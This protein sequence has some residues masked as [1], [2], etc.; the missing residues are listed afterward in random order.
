MLTIGDFD[1]ISVQTGT[2]RLDGGAMFGVVPK[3]IWGRHED[4]DEKNR[5]L[6]ATRSLIAASRDRKNVLLVDTGTGTKWAQEEADRFEIRYDAEAIPRAL[7]EHFKLTVRDVTDIVVTHL[8][9]DHNGGL[10][11]WIDPE[12]GST[13]P[14]YAQARHWIHRQHFQHAKEPN[15]RDRASFLERDYA[16]LEAA[17]LFSFVDGDD[18]DAPW[19]SVHWLVSHGH[20]P[21]QLL[22][23]FRDADHELIFT[24]DVFPTSSHLPVSWVM[25][26]DLEPLETMAEKKRILHRCREH[27]TWL[28]F[29]HDVR[30]GG[31]EIDFAHDRPFV[32]RTLPL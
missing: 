15:E 13:Q 16:S 3:V 11:E 18:P 23:V 17:G 32:A 26:Y 27:K 5:I 31:A 29:P 6:M 22:P 30:L 19:D 28:A 2:F 25:A 12:K 8:H 24:G 7:D 9:F 21:F 20:T 10:T 1:I 4:T 14:R